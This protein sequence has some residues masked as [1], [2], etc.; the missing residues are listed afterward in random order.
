MD[1][2]G[3]LSTLIDGEHETTIQEF[4]IDLS[5]GGGEGD[6]HRTFDPVFLGFKFPGRS[7]FAGRGDGELAFRLQE[8]QGVACARSPVLLG[9][10]ED[11]VF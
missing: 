7:I 10:G 11:L 9:D 6:H 2:R 3:L 8:L 5:R 1:R 4:F